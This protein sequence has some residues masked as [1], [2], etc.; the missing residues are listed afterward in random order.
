[1]SLSGRRKPYDWAIHD[2]PTSGRFE[3][4]SAM[5]LHTLKA[6]LHS[7]LT[8]NS[9]G[10][11]ETLL[12]RRMIKEISNAEGAMKIQTFTIVAGSLACDA[13]CPFCVA[14]MTPAHGTTLTLPAPNWRNF[15]KACQLALMSGVTTV[16]ITGKGE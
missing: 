4:L 14:E 6:S 15:E 13:R 5:E 3:D 7:A 8:V 11:G 2:R 1:M 16:L 12:A 10:Y 9:L